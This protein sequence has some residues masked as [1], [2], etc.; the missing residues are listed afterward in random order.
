MKCKTCKHS[1]YHLSYDD[2]AHVASECLHP[3][4]PD[5]CC[6]TVEPDKEAPVWCPEAPQLE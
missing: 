5:D 2:G 1:Y 3:D 6:F 4:R